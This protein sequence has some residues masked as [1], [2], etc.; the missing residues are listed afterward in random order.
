VTGPRLVAHPSGQLRLA[1][2]PQQRGPSQL[3]PAVCLLG[4]GWRC[5]QAQLDPIVDEGFVRPEHRGGI[6]FDD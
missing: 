3:G 5:D 4:A 6:Y 2:Q 1:A